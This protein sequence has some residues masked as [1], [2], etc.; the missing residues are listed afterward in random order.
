MDALVQ[1]TITVKMAESDAAALVEKDNESSATGKEMEVPAKDDGEK[2]N[3]IVQSSLPV[4]EDGSQTKDD[5]LGFRNIL[6]SKFT[7]M[8]LRQE[9]KRLS[10]ID[11]D[12]ESIVNKM[13]RKR[14]SLLSSSS[15]N[16][17]KV[18]EKTLKEVSKAAET[19]AV[20]EI[21][22]EAQKMKIASL[23][24][25]MSNRASLTSLAQRKFTEP[26]PPVTGEGA[27][28]TEENKLP[29]VNVV[30]T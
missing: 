6:A 9:Q 2:S 26:G 18:Q 23:T 3:D 15:S 20:L 16:N 14:D 4:D 10:K 25:L 1:P 29:D 7:A 11:K 27:V 8:R 12:I 21:D 28:A 5:F 19:V 13:S 24:E 30:N 22:R 17:P